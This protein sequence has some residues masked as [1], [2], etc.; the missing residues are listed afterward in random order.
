MATKGTAIQNERRE[1]L[2][3]CIDR[4]SKPRRSCS[5][6]R[7]VINPIR[8]ERYQQPNAAR[9]RDFARVAQHFAA[10]TEHDWQFAR[11]YVKAVD[12]SLGARVDARVEPLVRMSVAIEKAL[13]PQHIGIVGAADDDRAAPAAP[14]Q[15]DA[16]QYQGPHDPLAEFGFLDEQIAQAALRNHQD[17][18]RSSRHAIDQRRSARQLGEFSHERARPVAHDQFGVAVADPLHDVDLAGQ[19]D[20]GPRRDLAGAENAR[21]GWI[22]S[23]LA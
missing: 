8:F 17:F 19:Q 7:H 1:A 9:Q 20:K 14:Q 12:Q 10:R 15:R 18:D 16:A 4:G 5:D 22:G 6:D 21:A 2:G 3:C 13:Q 11:R 23:A